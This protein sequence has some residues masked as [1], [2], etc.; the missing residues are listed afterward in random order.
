M[1]DLPSDQPRAPHPGLA[2]LY[3]LGGLP[4]QRALAWRNQ[5]LALAAL[6]PV[7]DGAALDSDARLQAL[8]QAPL[9]GQALLGALARLG[10]AGPVPGDVTDTPTP[11]ARRPQRPI[12]AAPAANAAP[13]GSAAALRRPASRGADIG[14]GDSI[15]APG[16]GAPRWA[17]PTPH[18]SAPGTRGATRWADAT[19][20]AAAAGQA[21][22]MPSPWPLGTHRDLPPPA[23]IAAMASMADRGETR[24]GVSGQWLRLPLQ[25]PAAKQPQIAAAAAA[26][27][28]D[29]KAAHAE[30]GPAWHQVVLPKG[31]VAANPA[32]AF[33]GFG[34][35]VSPA[36]ADRWA[37]DP[38]LGRPASSVSASDGNASVAADGST[39]GASSDRIGQGAA[40]IPSR[41]TRAL[42]RLAPAR[43]V[44]SGARPAAA[45]ASTVQT[46][47]SQVA[48]PA[49]LPLQ[50]ARIGGFRG[51]AELGRALTPMRLAVEA[52]AATSARTGSEPS[53]PDTQ[54]LIDQ[55][56]AALRAQAMR[57][58][59]ALDG[60]AA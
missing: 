23:A 1:S 10:V 59:I 6:D 51:L 36:N 27:Y 8:V 34:S 52:S 17:P 7:L 35:A 60:G 15:P 2:R 11:Q 9:L 22:P 28:F 49:S 54:A 45:M 14:A 20:G 33:V 50:A 25:R 42:D 57:S 41:L 37:A 46:R 53:L 48:D 58:G 43:A 18:S 3:R 31:L 21:K 5:G 12:G 38:A 30:V 39:S 40:S 56:E 26:G 55:I 29:A 4:A 44:A 47:A 16:L 13:A 24:A 19:Q 32:L